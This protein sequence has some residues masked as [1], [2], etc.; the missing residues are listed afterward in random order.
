MKKG[1]KLIAFVL[2]ASMVMPVCS[3]SEG[4]PAESNNVTVTETTETKPETTKETTSETTEE[5]T[6][7]TEA[8]INNYD[9]S[10]VYKVMV[11]ALGKDVDSAQALFEEFFGMKFDRLDPQTLEDH[12]NYAIIIK[13][14]IDNVP[15]KYLTLTTQNNKDIVYELA[16]SADLENKD[17]IHQNYLKF[18]EK[19]QG[20][21]G[22]PAGQETQDSLEYTVF[23]LNKNVRSNVGAYYEETNNS[24][25]FDAYNNSLLKTGKKSKKK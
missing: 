7:T 8:P 2:I 4:K 5:P 14:K 20:L 13:L 18:T 23:K 24:F 19:L 17:E 11:K 3:C 12:T 15:C 25:W 6:T 10:E 21:Y 1:I 22:K 16:F 9:L